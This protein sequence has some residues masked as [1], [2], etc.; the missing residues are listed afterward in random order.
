MKRSSRPLIRILLILV[1][2]L[3]VAV[4]FIFMPQQ[5]NLAAYQDLGKQYDV[6]I[7]RDTWGVPHIFGKSDPDAAFGLAYAHS[8]D[9]FLTI[10]QTL[11]AARGRFA[12]VYGK[13]AAAN[14]YMVLLLRIGE[15]VNAKYESDL[16]PDSRALFE[17]YAAGLNY[18]AALD[19]KSP[20]YADQSQLFAEEQLKP[21]RL[22][23]AEI[24]A[25][26]ERDYRPG[27]KLN[28]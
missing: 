15:V 13:E 17:A 12:S 26:L 20:H 16:A 28:H 5:V 27:E 18:Y 19:A 14:D 21:V 8:E 23:E 10:Q 4:T 25:H 22:D 9:D 1:L 3:L 7:L 11:L 24:R 6:H 2:L